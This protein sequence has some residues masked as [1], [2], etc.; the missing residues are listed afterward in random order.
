MPVD[1]LLMVE[2]HLASQE[3][4]HNDDYQNRTEAPTIIMVW[5]AHIET[6][7]A[8]KENQNNQKQD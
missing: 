6:A 4:H 7:T 1:P 8:E 3:K 5:S 2:S